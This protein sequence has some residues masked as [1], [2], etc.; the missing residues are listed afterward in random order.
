MKYLTLAVILLSSIPSFSQVNW[1][2]FDQKMQEQFDSNPSLENEMY[3]RF[4]RISSGQIVAQD[5]VDPIIIPVVVH[6][7]H[8]NEIGNISY[9]QILD[10]IK[11]L[12]E[13][14][15]LTNADAGSIR[16]TAT[17]PF[18]P[19]AANMEVE[20][21]LAQIDPN[22]NCTNGIERRNSVEGT[23]NG[24][25]VVSK[26]YVAG[27]LDAWDRNKYF[28]IWVV[29]T[30]DN[31]D[32]AG[33]IL[34]YAQFP[35]GGSAN[36][37]GVIIR[38]DAFGYI[39][40]A[41]G[42]R[43][44]SHEV[45]HCFG[46]AHTFQSGCG[47]N[48]S[49][50]GGQGDGCCDTPPVDDP[51]WSCSQSQNNCSQVPNGD[52]YGFDA[53][54]QYE[55]F[56]SYSPCQYM[57]STDQKNIVQAN[58]S[59]VGHLSNLSSLTSQ[60]DAGVNLPAV[61]C[62]ADFESSV[63]VVCVG[64]TIDFS[65]YSFSGVV[66]RNWAFQG[67]LPLTSTD[68]V[69]TVTYN[70]PGI[71]EV[72][73]SV[74]DGNSSQTET[75]VNYISVLPN[76]GV[77]LPYIEGFETVTF[78]DNY[79]FFLENDDAGNTWAVTS[80]AS[81]S[82]SKSIKMSN[83]NVDGGSS[84]VFISGPIDLSVVDPSET[85]KFTFRYAYKQRY[86]DNDEWLKF[87][88]SKDCGLTWSLRKNIHGTN[89][90]SQTTTFDYVPEDSDNWT[91]VSITNITSSYF[92]PNFRYKFEFE[93]DFG[94]NIYIDDINIFPTSWSGTSSL[95][96]S[97]E[98]SVYPN[99]TENTINIKLVSP[100]SQ[101]ISIDIYNA[102]GQKVNTIFTGELGI[103]INEYSTSLA[104]LAKGVYYVKING[105]SVTKTVKITKN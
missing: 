85:L 45:G 20:F 50:C 48:G 55:N 82:G 97:T 83:Y 10:A 1:C 98:L 14:F 93:G 27:G 66:G 96:V 59:S 40:T 16:N 13:D 74:T 29:N 62:E 51:H 56:M 12:N 63:R 36:T 49:N 37:Y 103:G 28:N 70:T 32:A 90:N 33:Y 79:N 22:G 95:E 57:F 47:G 41:N 21:A 44:I 24:D 84:D 92:E 2:G 99:P 5:R 60:T 88:V 68:S 80:D 34:G 3:E 65:D 7:L 46:L 86:S 19:V 8:D 72:S 18:A 54:D 42:D 94:N 61:L 102:V 75:R 71:Y 78:P 35:F 69:V 105:E 31:G 91:Y 58:L 11:M 25:D 67:G 30:I 104:T 6:I 26:T 17:A 38:H 73:L 76:P 100:I 9:A 15:S 77:A 52:F 89:L 43:T 81:Y 87:Y 101:N 53:L 4:D 23:Y 39:G 64:S